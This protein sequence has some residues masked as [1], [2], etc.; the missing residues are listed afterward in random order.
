MRYTMTDRSGK[1]KIDVVVE[2]E[3][4]FK[5]DYK[6]WFNSIKGRATV[7][8]MAEDAIQEACLRCIRFSDSY[9]GSRPFD[10]WFYTIM[11][12]AL[13]DKLKEDKNYGMSF[14]YN[15]ELSIA[16]DRTIWD[17]DI[18]AMV[19]EDIK[20]LPQPRRDICNLY[21]MKGYTPRDISSVLDVT[22]NK[23]RSIVKRFKRTLEAKY[24][25]E[26]RS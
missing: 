23:A 17:Y 13:T 1:S 14:E 3:T 8:E 2:L 7:P 22:N 12:N 20:L 18:V 24:G 19:N 21:F 15:D 25:K 16:P 26:M 11:R 6:K 9:D 10:E 5:T 4:R